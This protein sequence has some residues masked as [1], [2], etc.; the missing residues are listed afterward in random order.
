MEDFGF[1]LREYSDHGARLSTPANLARGLAM[2]AGE[3]WLGRVQYA[4]ARE[5]YDSILEV[6][7]EAAAQASRLYGNMTELPLV[8]MPASEPDGQQ[9]YEAARKL[10]A[11]AS[12]ISESEADIQLREDFRYYIRLVS[13]YFDALYKSCVNNDYK[14]EYWLGGLLR[15]WSHDCGMNS[16]DLLAVFKVRHDRNCKHC[17]KQ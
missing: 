17:S 9:A 14:Q 3:E 2:Q 8:G 13:E 1:P 7:D 12:G 6:S 4:L 5:A 11:L 16:E 10:F 15:F